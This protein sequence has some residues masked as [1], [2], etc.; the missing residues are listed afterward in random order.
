MKAEPTSTESHQDRAAPETVELT[1]AGPRAVWRDYRES[2]LDQMIKNTYLFMT[3][4]ACARAGLLDRLREGQ[5]ASEELFEGMD[6]KLAESVVRYLELQGVVED[7]KEG[8][9][10]LTERGQLLTSEAS[11]AM[12]GFYGE[13]YGPVISRAADL[14]VSQATYGRNVARDT[15]A[16]GR[17]SATLFHRFH[18]PTVLNALGDIDAQCILDV[19]CGAGRLL[20]D[21]CAQNPNL[22]GVGL[23]IS[24]DAIDVARQLAFTAGVDD[25]LEFV[26][27]DAFHPESWPAVCREADTL[28]AVGVVHEF[29]RE[30]EERVVAL[31][32]TFA[33]LL[34]SGLKGFILGE[35]QLR[36]DNAEDDSEFFLVHA[37]TAQGFPLRRELW[38][39][40]LARTQLRCRRLLTR[41]EAGQRLVF[42]D[43]VPT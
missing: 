2:G 12:L 42:Y 37:L 24:P 22:R 4:D 10:R 26:V 39:D 11:R 15:A 36:Y 21:A 31:F 28:V 13:A 19:G 41:P 32:D 27:G 33:E 7:G 1:D 38:L 17:H 35:P 34:R 23:D 5:T 43:L 25:R 29:F 6:R 3:L 18:T 20:V 8:A 9:W 40:I 14:L 30:G 16:L